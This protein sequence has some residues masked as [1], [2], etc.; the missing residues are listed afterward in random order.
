M[1]KGLALTNKVHEKLKTTAEDSEVSIE[2]LGNTLLLHAL[3]DEVK[4]R[5][6]KN[7]IYAWDIEGTARMEEREL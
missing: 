7:L 2:A 5:Q 1:V 3:C 6:A 4:V